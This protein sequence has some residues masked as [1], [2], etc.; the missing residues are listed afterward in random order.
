M[1]LRSIRRR[2]TDSRD[3]LSIA[4][5][6]STGMWKQYELAELF[7]VSTGRISQIINDTYGEMESVAD[8]IKRT[9]FE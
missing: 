6:Y 8:E 2:K 9:S 3:R 4:W 7:G 1:P 5:L